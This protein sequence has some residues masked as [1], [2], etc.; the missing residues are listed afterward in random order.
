M[1][2]TF[3]YLVVFLFVGCHTT[4]N[5]HRKSLI[6][7]DFITFDD[8]EFKKLLNDSITDSFADTLFN[9]VKRENCIKIIKVTN[10]SDSSI[11]VY[12]FD[13]NIPKLSPEKIKNYTLDSNNHAQIQGDVIIEL[14]GATLLEIKPK[15][16]KSFLTCPRVRE[17]YSYYE[18]DFPYSKQKNVDSFDKYVLKCQLQ[19][20]S[21]VK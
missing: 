16:N 8:V 10:S 20:D 13:R 6:S 18:L 7:F 15:S 17:G 9:Q 4:D 2:N 12:Y 19:G 11:W 1:K 5:Q 3:F 21:L 14:F